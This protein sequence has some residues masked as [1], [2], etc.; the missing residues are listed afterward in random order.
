MKIKIMVKGERRFWCWFNLTYSG[1]PPR[2]SNFEKV[3][4]PW[5]LILCLDIRNWKMK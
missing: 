4:Q 1:Q 3:E 5:N 2:A